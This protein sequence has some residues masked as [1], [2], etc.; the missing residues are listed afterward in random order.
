MNIL[1]GDIIGFVFFFDLVI[2][3]FVVVELSDVFGILLDDIGEMFGKLVLCVVFLILLILG[4]GLVVSIGF[5]LSLGN[6]FFLVGFFMI[7]EVDEV[8]VLE[9]IFCLFLI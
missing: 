6:F 3:K 7:V 5:E 2:F 9:G 8:G 4:G 1:E